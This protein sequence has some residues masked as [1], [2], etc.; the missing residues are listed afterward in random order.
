MKKTL[1]ILALSLLWWNI[2]N[3]GINAEAHVVNGGHDGRKTLLSYGK[4]IVK[5]TLK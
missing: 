5:E 4:D 2:G 1:L 3:A